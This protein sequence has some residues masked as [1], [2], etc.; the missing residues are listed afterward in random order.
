MAKR[1]MKPGNMLYP[2]P[3]VMVS[4]RGPEGNTDIV[5]AAWA[6]TVCSD[7]PMISVSLKKSRFSHDLIKDSGEFVVNLTTES[8]TRAT[9]LCGV[10]SGRDKNKWEAAD[11]HEEMSEKVKAPRI[12]ESPVSIECKVRNILELGSHDMFI[13]EVVAV[14]A[15]AAF[16]DEKNRFDMDKCKLIAYVH[17]E[18]R[19]LSKVL[20]TFG[21]SV[22]KKKKK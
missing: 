14:G 20:G 5:T 2:V 22:R 6:G 1:S 16:F 10:I 3:A 9:D 21:F 13:G 4:C 15:D 19:A 8:L 18:Y 12:L 11:L 17:G 7:P